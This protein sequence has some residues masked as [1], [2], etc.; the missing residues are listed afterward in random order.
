MR[1]MIADIE[2][3][4]GNKVTDEKLRAAV[5]KLNEARR[6]VA[7]VYEL[8]KAKNPVIS[9]VETLQIM[10]ASTDLPVD[11]YIELLKAFLEDAPN[12]KPITDYR[13]RLL[14]IGSALDNPEYIKVIEDKGGLV[15][16]DTLCFGKMA[17]GDEIVIDDSDVLGSITDHYLKRLVCPRMMDKH[18]QLHDYIIQTAREYSCD[19]VLYQMMQ[20][21]ECWG[22]ENTLL[23]KRLKDEGIPQLTLEREEIMANA[24]QLAV[25]AEAFI[26]MI[27]EG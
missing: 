10:L 25:R 19:G 11:E 21:C 1:D 6:L 24:G 26:E 23:E 15:V 27:E 20:Y 3:F 17:F 5:A 14:L 22:G 7:Q 16:A 8:R 9:G 2:A 4:T 13:A 18:T 12:R